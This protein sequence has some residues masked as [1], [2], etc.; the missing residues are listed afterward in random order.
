MT[1]AGGGISSH[2]CTLGFLRVNC[3]FLLCDRMKKKGDFFNNTFLGN[4]YLRIMLH[5]LVCDSGSHLCSC[6]LELSEKMQLEQAVFATDKSYDYK[7]W[8][9]KLKSFSGSATLVLS[10]SS[11][12][13]PIPQFSQDLV[14][15][16]L[17]FAAYFLFRFH[18]LPEDTHLFLWYASG[19][20]YSLLSNV[21]YR[22]DMLYS[23]SSKVAEISKFSNKNVRNICV[24]S[25]PNLS[26]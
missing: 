18:L 4:I 8:S 3:L 19:N 22:M 21:S 15:Q 10:N 1:T 17:S 23:N 24:L 6:P 20:L 13:S 9:I 25:V 2:L 12:E 14:E 7:S 5:G 11:A 16:P 26:F